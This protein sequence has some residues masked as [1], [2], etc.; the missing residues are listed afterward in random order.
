MAPTLL[1]LYHLYH[2]HHLYPR[3]LS[4]HLST[5]DQGGSGAEHGTVAPL[6]L[7]RV[8][9]VLV[10]DTSRETMGGSDEDLKHW[11]L[12]LQTNQCKDYAKIYNHREGCY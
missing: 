8:T 12:E 7:G 10:T 2:L 1:Y 6:P 9:L 4:A 3:H 5:P 11:I